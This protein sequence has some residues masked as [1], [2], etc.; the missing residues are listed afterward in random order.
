[1]TSYAYPRLSDAEGMLIRQQIVELSDPVSQVLGLVA[2]E[3]PAAKPVETGATVATA[4]LIQDV[5]RAVLSDIEAT[6]LSL[7]RPIPRDSVAMFDQALGRSLHQALH[8]V[9]ADAAHRATWNFLTGVVF[10]DIAWVR[11]PD[12]HEDRFL[13]SDRNVLRRVWFRHEVLG[14]L[15]DAAQKPLGEDELVGLLERTSHA[16]NRRLARVLAVK[17]MEYDGARARSHV[18]REVYKRATHFTGPLL[19]DVLSEDQLSQL[20]SSL[21][22]GA[23]WPPPPVDVRERTADLDRAGKHRADIQFVDADDVAREGKPTG[24]L[25]REFHV[26]MEQLFSRTLSETGYRASK[27]LAMVTDLGGLET[28]RRLVGAPNPSEGFSVLWELKRLDLTA[29]ALALDV[30]FQ[31]LFTDDLL[32][33]ARVRL[34]EYGYLDEEA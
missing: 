11:F 29:E 14:D 10:P 33:R 4:S 5:R 21:F 19:L 7:D 23:T 3:H 9:P 25:V 30:R 17:V 16:R 32:E 6:G 20:V 8:V 34:D 22:T 2:F 24:D 26:A 12:L 13:G 27:F 28:A 18:A 15:M 1:M 31:G